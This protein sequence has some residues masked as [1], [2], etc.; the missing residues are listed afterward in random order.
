MKTFLLALFLFLV[1][2]SFAQDYSIV[3]SIVKNYPKDFKSIES[4]ADKID[5]DFDTDLEK[6]RAAYYWISNN[7]I[8]DYKSAN[9]VRISGYHYSDDSELEKIQL[10][11]SE[12]V[13]KEKKA[14]CEGYAQLLK[15]VLDKIEIK[16]EVIDGYAK[17]DIREIGKVKNEENHAWNAVYLDEKWQLIDATWSTGNEENRQD[18]FEFNDAYFLIKPE[19]LVWSH[20]PDDKKWQLLEKP[21]SS[22]TFFYSPIIH[23]GFYNSGLEL[24]KMKGTVKSSRTIQIS[25]DSVD[26]DRVYYYQF[27]NSS[28]NLEPITF[29]KKGDK[30]IAEIPYNYKNGKELI[31]YVDYDAC[32]SFKII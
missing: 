21:I 3:D 32:L 12:N 16:C 5:S 9:S 1:Q 28:L 30:Q 19:Y 17:T 26:T 8:Y 25:F 29:I 20:F 18:H 31:I 4:F 6:T 23:P 14:V 2:I 7:I 13:L 24:S 22:L 27:T 15:Y 11:Y 10:E